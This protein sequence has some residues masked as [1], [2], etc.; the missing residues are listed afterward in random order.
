MKSWEEQGCA[1]C[2]RQ[3][4]TAERPDFVAENVPMHV[5][6]YRCSVCRTWWTMDERLAFEATDQEVVTYFGGD[7]L[8]DK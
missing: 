2:R 5:E 1:L 7:V 4:E 3:W 8:N 6:L